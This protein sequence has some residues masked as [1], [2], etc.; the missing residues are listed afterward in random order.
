L[1]NRRRIHEWIERELTQA[2][3]SGR[4]L[5][6]A[7]IDIDNFKAV[8]DTYGHTA[9]DNALKALAGVLSRACRGTDIAARYA[10]DEFLLVLPGLEL[11]DAHLVGQ[12]LLREVGRSRRSGGPAIGVE[13]SISIGIA[14]SREC[15]KPA[16]QLIAIA[17]AAMYDAKDAG[18]NQFVLANADTKVLDITSH[19]RPEAL[20]PEDIEILSTAG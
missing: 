16:K 20:D 7:L 10:G 14:V 5:G 6:L 11:Q 3:A 13:I 1:P 19:L 17:D 4:S 18:K 9:G 12:R 8:N 2:R 15:V